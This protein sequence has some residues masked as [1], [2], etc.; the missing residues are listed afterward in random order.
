ME[1]AASKTSRKIECLSDWDKQW[2][3]SIPLD[4]QL[5]LPC[6]WWWR[7]VSFFCAGAFCSFH[8]FFF[9]RCFDFCLP[10]VT[11]SLLSQKWTPKRFSNSWR[12]KYWTL[13]IV[14]H[15]RLNF[16]Y[17]NSYYSWTGVRRRHLHYVC[18]WWQASSGSPRCWATALKKQSP[19][20]SFARTAFD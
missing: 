6:C 11:R 2:V 12:T 14:I 7:G 20:P 4:H 19:C 3:L 17:T 10:S 18:S 5:L 13:H 1:C 15:E 8:F 9:M 16:T